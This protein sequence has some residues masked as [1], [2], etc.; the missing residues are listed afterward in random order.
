MVTMTLGLRN[1]SAT[2]QR[3]MI[4]IMRNFLH[5][6]ITVYLDDVCV[7]SNTL[8]EHLEHLCLALLRFK[9]EGLTS[10]LM[11]C[12]LRLH[13]MECLGYTVSGVTILVPTNKVDA[14]E[15]WALSYDVERSSQLRAILQLLRRVFSS[16]F[17]LTATLSVLLGNSQ[18]HKVTLTHARL[19]AFDTL[20]KRLISDSCPIPP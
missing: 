17:D 7:N 15:Y 10:R 14:F 9:E 16:F 5:N 13:D 19:G 20:S 6:L 4:D 8:E 1:A 2:F 11:K 18:P 3:M 12:L